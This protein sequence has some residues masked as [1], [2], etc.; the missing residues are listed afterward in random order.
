[1]KEKD[2]KGGRGEKSKQNQTFKY[3]EMIIEK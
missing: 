3:D 2:G 1:M